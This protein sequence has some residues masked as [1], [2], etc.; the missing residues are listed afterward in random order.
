MD[1]RQEH[2]KQIYQPALMVDGNGAVIGQC[3]VTDISA[4][5]TR[6]QI[7]AEASPRSFSIFLSKY[8]NAPKRRSMLVWSNWT[9]VRIRFA[10]SSA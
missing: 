4:G 2:R 8:H 1:K 3:I 7:P 10:P 5:G 6:L 9:Q